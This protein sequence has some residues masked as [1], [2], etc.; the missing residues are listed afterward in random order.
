MSKREFFAAESA[1]QIIYD[2]L[3]HQQQNLR[4][5]EDYK[6]LETID[7]KNEK[8]VFELNLDFIYRFMPNLNIAFID[9][10][11]DKQKSKVVLE[12]LRKLMPIHSKNIKHDN[13]EQNIKIYEKD[14]FLI[15]QIEN[16]KHMYS[17]YIVR[18][19]RQVT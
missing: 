17:F 1:L 19:L 13:F 7:N 12:F 4:K 2:D 6:L 16:N 10:E 3:E 15:F 18:L 14:N 11:H 8:K 9:S 5:K